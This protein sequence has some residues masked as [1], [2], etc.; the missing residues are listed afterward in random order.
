L[1][2]P[3]LPEPPQATVPTPPSQAAP[4]AVQSPGAGL[5]QEI[6]QPEPATSA[7]DAKRPSLEPQ[8]VSADSEIPA[9]P[10]DVTLPSPTAAEHETLSQKNQQTKHIG[11][12]PIFSFATEDLIDTTQQEGGL[13]TDRQGNLLVPVNDEVFIRE[14]G[15]MAHS[16]AL[17]FRSAA[18]R[19]KGQTLDETVEDAGLGTLLLASGQGMV[20]SSPGEGRFTVLQLFDD[21]IYL[22]QEA[23]FAF[24]S[25]LYWENGRIHN[26]E[27]EIPLVHLRGEGKLA[28]WSGDQPLKLRVVPDHPLKF[29]AQFLL[30]W[31]GRVIPRFLPHPTA[32]SEPAIP[33]LICEGEGVLLM[34]T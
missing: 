7:A 3:P 11:S 8:T 27:T 18:K 1:P 29:P 13:R 17:S 4:P 16:G 19:T 2:Q 21:F 9:V 31:L 5:E 23:L 32:S 34:R 25:S 24:E 22:R 33:N 26:P 14:T 28:L 10:D 12:I 30:G 6:P 20:V 15:M